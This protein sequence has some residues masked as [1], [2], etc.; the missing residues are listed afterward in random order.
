MG[1]KG[2]PDAAKQKTTDGAIAFVKYYVSVLNET[3]YRPKAGLL[4]PFSSDSCV[5]CVNFEKS[6]KGRIERGWRTDGP[7][8]QSPGRFSVVANLLDQSVPS[9]HVLAVHTSPTIHERTKSGEIAQ[10][11][12]AT[13]TK[14]VYLLK[15]VS[16]SWSI[17]DIQY[18]K[19]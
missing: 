5:T 13:T 3:G 12:N 19:A 6:V 4:E 10:T 1:I 2:L 7:L 8:Y 15:W 11:Y 16:N 18:E 17:Q 14:D 9:V